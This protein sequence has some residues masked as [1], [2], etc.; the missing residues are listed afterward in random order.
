[1]PIPT[2]T[3]GRYAVPTVTERSG[4]DRHEAVNGE[5]HTLR[6]V[7]LY[8]NLDRRAA[9]TPGLDYEATPLG[10]GSLIPC[11]G[12]PALQQSLCCWLLWLGLHKRGLQPAAV[13]RGPLSWAAA[14]AE[15]AA[16]LVPWLVGRLLRSDLL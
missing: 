5:N 11:F 10:R 3:L 15:R 2:T 9:R 8:F 14:L 16:Q 13:C 7:F 12:S 6:R 1:V 4:G